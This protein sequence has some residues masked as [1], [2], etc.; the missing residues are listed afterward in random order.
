MKI[1][2]NH[3]YEAT[4]DLGR[5]LGILGL[6]SL[7]KENFS[8]LF[9]GL[10]SDK[11]YL[12]EIFDR[13]VNMCLEAESIAVRDSTMS[14][15]LQASKALKHR[16]LDA[17]ALQCLYTFHQSYTTCTHPMDSSLE[18]TTLFQEYF[19]SLD[20]KTNSKT[21]ISQDLKSFGFNAER[22]ENCDDTVSLVDE[23]MISYHSMT[24][25]H[26]SC[27][28]T[29]SQHS[30]GFIKNIA[31]T[32]SETT[33]QGDSALL[34]SSTH[35]FSIPL[36][37]NET[38]STHAVDTSELFNG[39]LQ[40]K[41]FAPFHTKSCD[42]VDSLEIA[43]MNHDA[44]HHHVLTSLSMGSWGGLSGTMSIL[45]DFM[46]AY[47][48]FTSKFCS[49]LEETIAL[50]G[51]VDRNGSY[52]E[53]LKENSN[54]EQGHYDE[55][56]IEMIK[57]LGL[58]VEKVSG[59]S[60][61][62]L[63]VQCIESLCKNTRAEN[64]SNPPSLK[65]HYEYI[66]D[67]LTSAFDSACLSKMGANAATAISAIFFG[68]EL[69]ASKMYSK[70]CAFLLS[71]INNDDSD[72]DLLIKKQDL[73]FFLLHIDMDIEHANK[74]RKIVIDLADDESIRIEITHV[75][76]TILNARVEFFDRFVEIAFPPTGHSGED[77][78]KL[79]NK[80]SQNWV[81]KGA[82]C[83]SDFTG[84][85]VVFEMC[86][87]HASGSYILDVGCGE[88]YGARELVKMGA[89]RIIGF[90]ISSEMIERA[91]TNPERSS[92]RE[93]YQ[94][95]DA[96]NIMDTLRKM[97][98]TLGIVPGRI[99]EQGCFDLAVAIFLFNYTS[100]SKMKSICHQ[101]YKALRPGGH[102]VFSVP[103]PF[104]L[105]SHSNNNGGDDETEPSTFSFSKGNVKSD[106]YF[107]L[108]DRKFAGVI[109]TLD[110][111][112]LN[113]KML[114]KSI[115]D[116]TETLNQVGF[117]IEKMREARVLPEH[118]KTH[119][120]FFA[121]VKDVP[122]HLVFDVQKPIEC[123]ITNRIPRA[124]EWT[125]FERANANRILSISM[126]PCVS[127]ELISIAMEAHDLGMTVD[128]FV[129][130]STDR[131]RLSNVAS[132]GQMLRTRLMSQTGAV[133]LTGLDLSKFK[134]NN[135]PH[136]SNTNNDDD[137][138]WMRRSKLAYYILSCFIGKVDDDARGRLFDV[139]DQG[140]DTTND[141][142]LFSVS[143]AAAP[144]H[145]DG[146][147]AEK[148][149]DGV[150][151]LCLSPAA[152]GGGGALHLSNA[153]SALQVLKQRLPKFVLHEL[154]RP[155][156][157]DI[158]ENGSGDGV[159]E[160]L[161]ITRRPDILKRRVRHN[162]F[163]IFE[164]AIMSNVQQEEESRLRFRYMRQWIES[165]HVKGDVPLSPLL[166]L[167]LNALDQA[168]EEETI[169]ASICLKEGEMLFCNNM[170]LAHSRDEF[171]AN[172]PR[173]HVRIWMKLQGYE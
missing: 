75:T 121:S 128:T 125:D 74:M 163:P 105:N 88:G 162:A 150:G 158:L 34:A 57:K 111:R 8:K 73:A 17:D 161:K 80:Q 16:E 65:D 102:F 50:V 122:L 95:C 87:A 109:R 79:Y 147:S 115:S 24:I 67:P 2:S 126:P 123:A 23:L 56:S 124:I 114:F 104:M 78:A 68:S 133:H 138:E 120:Q 21:Q 18:I 116:Y 63:Y 84:R 113:V 32:L 107:S 169:G 153:Y 31:E 155:L 90:D 101:I 7:N 46:G 49:Y 64:L 47:K 137:E 71:A 89:K 10:Q 3:K 168:L 54:E 25:S 139:I 106:S 51:Q 48:C 60:H 110:G 15:R 5:L 91:R 134:T 1:L 119:P 127:E 11:D 66:A 159:G 166:E 28:L 81:R 9:G 37:V 157:R 14:G 72:D 141:N 53:I 98:A 164:Q 36:T 52:V 29:E 97:P 167:A 20:N 39:A 44:L 156:P 45:C 144:W 41:I 117:T 112:D 27:K 33:D 132:F 35:P 62:D 12:G 130:T 13:L 6:P 129:P 94:T 171:D 4:G 22:E 70:L 145:T 140:L 149:Y 42:F 146:A 69:V 172:S 99:L 160:S 170:C 58:D 142:V 30:S 103:H 82:T 59:V 136:P 135:N 76:E 40:D 85:P 165:G 108:R 152:Q 154:F 143:S 173:H 86:S 83:L 93:V 96:E 131:K 19:K 92:T 26:H 100:I 118:V 77:S 38:K 151:L 61:R 55:D 43:V 148:S